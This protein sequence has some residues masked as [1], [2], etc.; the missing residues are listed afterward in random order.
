MLLEGGVLYCFTGNFA[1]FR[2]RILLE[3]DL[4]SKNFRIISL[5]DHI[6]YVLY[7]TFLTKQKKI[8][9]RK[10]RYD[11]LMIFVDVLLLK[12]PD[13]GGRRVPDHVDPDPQHWYSFLRF[14][15]PRISL[16]IQS[17]I[18]PII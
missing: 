4:L 2:I 10:F 15:F 12:D 7:Y 11:F 18:F 3:S 6:I 17:N 8:S 14:S 9:L 13:P 16:T 1:K 5:E